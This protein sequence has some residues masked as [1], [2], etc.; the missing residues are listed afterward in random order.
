MVIVGITGGIGSGKST[1]CDVWKKE[2]AYILNADEFAKQLMVD[3]DEI[4]SEIKAAF[5]PESYTAEGELNRKFLSEEAFEKG[6]VDE[7]NAIIHPR[8]PAAVRERMK[9]AAEKGYK[10]GVYE[11]A[12][13]LE[14]DHLD[15]F[16]YLVLVLA[17]EK[18]RL[19]WV[20]ER[21]EASE[22]QVK[23]RMNKQRNFEN[24][25]SQADI[26]IRNEGTLEDLKKKAEVVFNKFL[27]S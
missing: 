5:G 26:V 12:L 19:Q 22:K 1:V 6:R 25:V 16:D 24:A 21:D 23:S 18:R 4:R 15:L 20:K 17:D 14:S 8:L 11:A 3:N 9:E 2:G 7:L 10:V 13:L 27:H